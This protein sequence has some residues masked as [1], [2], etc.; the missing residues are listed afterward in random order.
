MASHVIDLVIGT[1][2]A[3]AIH[4]AG[5]SS[6]NYLL[7]Y[8][9]QTAKSS[10]A[11]VVESLRLMVSGA[12]IDAVRVLINMIEA[13]LRYSD[14]YG[15]SAAE[16]PVYVHLQL[17]G[18]GTAYRSP[19]YS[20]Q[21]TLGDDALGYQWATQ[22][23]E[24]QLTWTRAAWWESTAQTTLVNAQSIYNRITT[25]PVSYVDISGSSIAGSIPSPIELTVQNTLNESYHIAHLWAGIQVKGTGWYENSWEAEGAGV[26]GGSSVASATASNG[27]FR[28][29][30]VPATEGSL[31]T[32]TPTVWNYSRGRWFAVLGCLASAP[33]S[34]VRIRW[35]ILYAGLAHWRGDLISISTDLM[36]IFGAIPVPPAL[37]GADS[38]E[39][40]TLRLRGL[41][42]GNLDIDYFRLLPVNSCRVYIARQLGAGYQESVMD[43][44][45]IAEGA[46]LLT[47]GGTRVPGFYA[48]YDPL[49]VWPG[50]DQRLYLSWCDTTTAKATWTAS[51]TV[52]HR[53][54]R[55]TL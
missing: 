27:Y 44:P 12:T 8:P 28:R 13:R 2:T 40:L 20:A 46:L 34:G 10:E 14:L 3:N 47:S 32:W 52:K 39:P 5:G 19:I 51:V 29:F 11:T 48:L 41:G 45:T 24:V 16:L 50:I 18:S 15:S 9:I 30:A 55:L 21:L 53:P 1:D 38:V 36:Q 25:A 43:D 42:S 26:S 35:E 23:I 7:D 31:A 22:L 17:G 4:L 33:N 54:R 49:V 6:G 37:E